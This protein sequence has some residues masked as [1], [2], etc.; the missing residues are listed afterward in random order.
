MRPGYLI[1]I[2]YKLCRTNIKTISLHFQFPW[3]TKSV[4][5]IKKKGFVEEPIAAKPLL[6]KDLDQNQIFG[7]I[8]L[9]VLENAVEVTKSRLEHV[10]LSI[11]LE[12]VLFKELVILNPVMGNGVAGQTGPYVTGHLLKNIEQGKFCQDSECVQFS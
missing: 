7:V 8:G 1:Y 9:N 2:Y 4:K 10:A 3:I 5:F 6:F 11:V 12:A